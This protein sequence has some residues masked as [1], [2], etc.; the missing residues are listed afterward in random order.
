MIRLNPLIRRKHLD[1]VT[2]SVEADL[3]QR[4]PKQQQTTLRNLGY[5]AKAIGSY[6]GSIQLT[7]IHCSKLR[8]IKLL[9]TELHLY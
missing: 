1:T 7:E 2:S 5:S 3:L 6:R 8:K 4:L 9:R